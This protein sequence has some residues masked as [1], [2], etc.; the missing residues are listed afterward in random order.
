[1]A[2]GSGSKTGL[3]IRDPLSGEKDQQK[4][5][6]KF[7]G[8]LRILI[9]RSSEVL[10]GG[11]SIII[12]NFLSKIFELLLTKFFLQFL[13]IKNLDLHTDP[14]SANGWIRILIQI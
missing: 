9:Y 1:L 3:G 5:L 4:G 7:F 10:H 13:V 11:L 14:E 2:F 8:G 6:K 12:L